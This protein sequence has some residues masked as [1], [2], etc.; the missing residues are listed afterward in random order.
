MAEAFTVD[1]EPA[2]GRGAVCREILAALPQWFGIPEANESY[3][4]FVDGHDSW[5][6]TADGAA[7]GVV[8][9]QCHFPETAE[10]ELLAVL[11]DWHRHGVGRALVCAFEAHHRSN[12][13]QMLEVKTLG[14]SNPDEGYARTR[15]FYTGIGFVPIEEL[16]LWAPDN[17]ALILCKP[18]VG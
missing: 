4:A 14:P 9:G 18:V 12:G 2:R 13:V 17:P 3:I 15:A 16:N 7:V 5:L 6:A 10:I 11:P 1:P 8:A